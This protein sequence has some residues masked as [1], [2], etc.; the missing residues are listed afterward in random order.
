MKKY[1]Y[2]IIHIDR[3]KNL[4]R[5]ESEQVDGAPVAKFQPGTAEEIIYDAVLKDLGNQ[6]WNLIVLN[7]DL[8]GQREIPEN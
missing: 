1:E 6:G 4:K 8:I 3:L 7:G 5:D 2:K